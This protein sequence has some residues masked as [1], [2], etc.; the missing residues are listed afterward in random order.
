MAVTRYRTEKPRSYQE[1]V[2]VLEAFGC[3]INEDPKGMFFMTDLSGMTLSFNSYLDLL[4]LLNLK[5]LKLLISP[6]TSLFV[7]T[8]FFCCLISNVSQC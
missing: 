1:A 2:H 4:P 5:L 6:K 7:D 3:D 8:R